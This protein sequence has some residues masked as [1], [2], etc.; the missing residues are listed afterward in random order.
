[1]REFFQL[2]GRGPLSA[3]ATAAADKRFQEGR[4]GEGLAVRNCW[5]ALHPTTT[6]WKDRKERGAALKP[7]QQ[8]ARRQDLVFRF[9]V[10]SESLASY[11]FSSDMK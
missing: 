6:R 2:K 9:P 11:I 4:A 1:M 10:T 3:A 7:D 8:G 5:N